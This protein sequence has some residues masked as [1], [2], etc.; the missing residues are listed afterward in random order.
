MVIALVGC[1]TPSDDGPSSEGM[2]TADATGTSGA[3]T[4]SES[5]AGSGQGSGPGSGADSAPDPSGGSGPGDPSSDASTGNPDPSTTGDPET[6]GS[7]GGST[8]APA[9]DTCEDL[10]AMVV[11]D[12]NPPP[13]E[14]R[15]EG[16]GDC[17]T[18]LDGEALWNY[19]CMWCH[20]TLDDNDIQD[21]SLDR[22]WWAVDFSEDLGNWPE[23]GLA[24]YP[25]A[26]ERIQEVL[27]ASP[28]A[29]VDAHPHPLPEYE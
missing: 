23:G 28:A 9:L 27:L 29:T 12:N 17:V 7:D 18:V 19:H 11:F 2:S 6:S 25:G 5:D 16:L 26:V 8:G 24:D 1:D 4:A 3:A 20:S 14:T 10:A 22:V 21:R 13:G 15:V